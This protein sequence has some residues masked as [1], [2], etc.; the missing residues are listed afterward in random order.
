MRFEPWNRTSDHSAAFENDTRHPEIQIEGAHQL[1][2]WNTQKWHVEWQTALE[3]RSTPVDH[4]TV[5]SRVHPETT[6][7]AQ[8]IGVVRRAE[9]HSF[10][11]AF[12]DLKLHLFLSVTG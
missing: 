4:L 11:R 2:G 9:E 8:F 5:P 6:L 7:S 1:A 10:I 12:T 3:L